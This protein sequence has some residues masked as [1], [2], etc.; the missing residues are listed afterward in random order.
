MREKL[1]RISLAALLAAAIV[2]APA[3]AGGSLETYDITGHVPS[4]VPGQINARVVRIFHDPRCIPVSFKINSTQDPIPNPLGS[5][6][7][8]KVAQARTALQKAFDTWNGIPTSYIEEKIVGTV[9]N[10][11]FVGWDMINEVSFRPQPA[12]LGSLI[13]LTTSVTL[14]QDTTLRDG[15]DINGDGIPDVSSHISNCIVGS[16]GRTKFPAGFYKAGTILDV[17]VQFNTAQNR[18]TVND[19]DVDTNM[20]SV[21]LQADATHEFGHTIGLSHVLNN[22]NSPTDGTGATMFPR[23]D[24]NDPPSEFAW[25]TLAGDD[26]AWASYLYPEGTAASGPAAIQPGDIPFN[27]VYGLIKGTVTHG[28]LNE[29][30]AGASV[31]ATN[32]LTN[33]MVSSAFSGT[34]QLTFDLA[35][36]GL[37]LIS[38]TYDILNG[39]YTMPV[40]LGLYKLGIEALDGAPVSFDE[41]NFTTLIGGIFGQ[42][43]FNEGVWGGPLEAANEVNPGLAIPVAGIPSLTVSHIDFVTNDQINISNFGSRDKVGFSSLPAGTYYAVRIPASQISAVNPGGNLYIQEALY[44]TFVFDSSVVPVFAEATL[45]TGTVNG[46]S[47]K[48]DLA[49]PLAKVTGFIGQENDFSPFYFPLPDLLGQVVKQKIAS[50]QT[51][52]LFLVLRLPTTTPFPGI[53]AISPQI[54]LDDGV[55]APIYGMSY[56]S[57]DGNTWTQRTDTNFRFALVVAKAR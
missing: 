5:G 19:S 7:V 37:G 48:V 31:S 16:D 17:D 11:G 22:Q 45:T 23:I 3:R 14:M 30:L 40:P 44:D 56:V 32:L 52:N 38:P 53:S 46:N 9:A 47:V 12:M 39:D 15:D 42:Q 4:P 18:F 13:G 29:P 36:G 26:I 34:T 1:A 55:D 24:L 28:A 43:S 54:W 10:P 57:T 49:H 35:T 20:L 25:R 50:G 21:D 8:V 33:E 2:S 27:F 41:V 6:P 51:Q